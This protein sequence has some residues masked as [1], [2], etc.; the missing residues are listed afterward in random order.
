MFCKSDP[1]HAM[2]TRLCGPSVFSGVD[3]CYTQ[4]TPPRQTRHR[5]DCFVVSVVAVWI[6]SARPPDRCVLCRFCVGLPPVPDFQDVP[7]LCNVV[8]RPSRTSP[9]T[10]N[11]PDFKACSLRSSGYTAVQSWGHCNWQIGSVFIAKL[12][13][14]RVRRPT[15]NCHQIASKCTKS[16]T[17]FQ[18]FSGGDTPG[19]PSAGGSP[20]TPVPDWESEKVA[21]LV[22]RRSAAAATQPGGQLGLAIRL[23]CRVSATLYATQNVNT[24]WVWWLVHMNM[25][26]IIVVIA[27]CPPCRDQRT[28]LV[29]FCTV[30]RYVAVINLYPSYWFQKQH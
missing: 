4:F 22:L 28:Q 3:G 27:F 12:Q 20:Q 6:E 24:L 8:P 5:L 2:W 23:E 15:N 26:R 9:G 17:E 16:Y 7:D 1:V 11:V 14:K 25:T 21:T 18:K 30:T 29:F 13:I 10:P 19:R